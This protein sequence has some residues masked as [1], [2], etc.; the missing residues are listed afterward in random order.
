[1]W[2][3]MQ[4]RLNY[5]LTQSCRYDSTISHWFA[6][7]RLAVQ[8]QEIYYPQGEELVQGLSEGWHY[9]WTQELLLEIISSCRAAS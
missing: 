1:M 3:E 9:S 5:G 4:F 6:P 7:P 2:E 8:F